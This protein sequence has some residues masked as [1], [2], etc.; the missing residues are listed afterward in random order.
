MLKLLFHRKPP[1][2]RHDLANQTTR[3]GRLAVLL[4]LLVVVLPHLLRLE[5]LLIL[6]ILAVIGWR[7]LVELRGWPLPQRL[8]RIALLGSGFALV[9][10]S[11][12]TL[13]GRLPGV[14]LLT[15]LFTLKL[16][17]LRTLRD[18]M[19]L[20]F[21]GFFL[22]ITNFLFDQSLF[23]GLYLFVTVL[24]LLTVLILLNHP[25]ATLKDLRHHLRLSGILMLQAAPLMLLFFLL[26][27]RISAPLW[28][29]PRDEA[30][31]K[32]GVSDEMKIGDIT[33]LA[34]S[35]AVA[36]RVDFAHEIPPAGQLY[37]RVY[38]LNLTNGRQWWRSPGATNAA[39]LLPEAI[40]Q[41]HL[42]YTVT[43][44][45]H[46]RNWLPALELPTQ[47][48]VGVDNPAT[49]S[50]DWQLSLSQ[51]L[52]KRVRYQLT[53]AT[54]TT[55][56]AVSPASL[57]AALQLPE[58]V[59]PRTIALGRHWATEGFHGQALVDHAL[60]QIAQ[61]DFY[62]SR[63]PPPL[64]RDAIDEFIFESKRGFCEHYAA[65]LTTVLRA[66]GLPARVVTGYQGGERNPVGNYLIVRQSSAHAWVE[67]YLPESGWQRV[68]PTTVVPFE[69]VENSGDLQRFNSVEPLPL[70][71]EDLAWLARSLRHLNQNWDAINHNWNDLIIG[72]NRERQRQLLAKLGINQW[73][74]ER[75]MLSI[76]ALVMLIW[77]AVTLPL[78]LNRRRLDAGQ[79]LFAKF[80]RRL[81]QHGMTTQPHQ[82]P[83]QIAATAA[84][85]WPQQQLLLQQI[86][87]AFYRLRYRPT[88]SKEEASQ[89]LKRVRALL[90]KLP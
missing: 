37:W 22:M 74:G 44:E 15:L 78:L 72:F 32:T 9:L 47:P 62:Y 77:G 48:P 61:G 80:R 46:R 23:V 33:H 88:A 6:F 38:I 24:L 58:G 36:F 85:R 82:T 8:L 25:R 26:F 19:L 1:D 59:N 13:L 18:A 41:Q 60:Q 68:D 14:A 2:K 56:P 67:Y 30:Q 54:T 39:T 76:T 69:R 79:R 70:S 63:N 43:L 50:D 17:E 10:F 40:D 83:Q 4:A 21:I 87:E 81:A 84:L 55:Q 34:D 16:V 53:S 31:A 89:Q 28:S 11:Y 7:L 12:H 49:L 90:A 27:P 42:S 57:A 86:A 3:L 65:A 75:L 45:P 35:Q 71:S 20:I 52:Q 73:S 29:L 51:P 5:P 64:G 66:A